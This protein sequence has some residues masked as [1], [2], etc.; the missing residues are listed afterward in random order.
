MNIIYWFISTWFL[1][2]LYPISQITWQNS[3]HGNTRDECIVL[4]YETYFCITNQGKYFFIHQFKRLVLWCKVSIC[5]KNGEILWVNGSYKCGR[6]LVIRN[7]QYYVVSHL[8]TE[9]RL[10]ANDGYAR[11]PPQCVKNPERF[12]TPRKWNKFIISAVTGRR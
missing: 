9:E 2:F 1:T 12:K 3:F 8:E 11:D 5:I 10:R 6:Y 4:V 7:F